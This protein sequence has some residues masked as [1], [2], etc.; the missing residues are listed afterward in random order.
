MSKKSKII[1]ITL[2]SLL[3][4]LLISFMVF[5][6]INGKNSLI[7]LGITSD[8]ISNNLIYN[9][10]Y[11]D[12]FDNINIKTDSSD[13]KIKK[14]ND[15]KIKVL[16][17]SEEEKVKRLD[18]KDNLSLN[19][20]LDIKN[21]FNFLM[22]NNKNS[23]IEVYIPEEYNKSIKIDNGYGNTDIDD[24]INLNMNIIS[25]C[26][27]IKIGSGNSIKI[28][29]SYGDTIINKSN[30]IDINNDCG[31]IEIGKTKS[32]ILK[33]SYGDIE[34]GNVS[35][36]ID[37]E[38]NCGDISVDNIS[39]IK[40]SSI[41]SDMGDVT[42]DNIKDIYIDAKTDLGDISVDNNYHTSNITLKIENDCGDIEV[43]N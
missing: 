3:V 40:N 1:L 16:I 32:A 42:I 5:V 14:S 25:D 43:N 11:E 15:S 33:N 9:K 13:I 35:E 6:I 29:N 30:I 24:F 26:G 34:I 37:I 31:D 20:N 18:V 7:N 23:K 27:D 10:E 19:I 41:K 4:V 39:L 8:K 38:D 17:Y 22:F 21:G 28:D 36:Y 2:L 12:K